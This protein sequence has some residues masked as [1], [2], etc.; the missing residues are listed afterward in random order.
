MPPY[1]AQLLQHLRKALVEKSVLSI[2]YLF[3]QAT[4]YDIIKRPE[5]S[6]TCGVLIIPEWFPEDVKKEIFEDNRDKNDRFWWQRAMRKLERHY[7]DKQ[8]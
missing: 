4:K 6:R 3:A 5:A 7:D 1:E 2:K 8:E